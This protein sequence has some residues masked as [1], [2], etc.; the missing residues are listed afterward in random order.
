MGANSLKIALA[1]AKSSNGALRF[2]ADMSFLFER[3]AELGSLV[4]ISHPAEVDFAEGS[5]RESA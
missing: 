2:A 1:V 5:V 4:V 3:A